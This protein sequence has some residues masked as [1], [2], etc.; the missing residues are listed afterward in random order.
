MNFDLTK[1]YLYADITFTILTLIG[2]TKRYHGPSYETYTNTVYDPH[3]L[4]YICL[5]QLQRRTEKE[6]YNEESDRIFGESDTTESRLNT[7][8]SHLNTTESHLKT[9]KDNLHYTKDDNVPRETENVLASFQKD[10]I[11]TC[12]APLQVQCET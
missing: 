12:S 6:V 7:T 11:I 4:S 5:D 1:S 9:N 8:E 2:D 3:K 10:D